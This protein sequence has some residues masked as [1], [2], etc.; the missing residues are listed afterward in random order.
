MDNY[1]NIATETMIDKDKEPYKII[2]ESDNYKLQANGEDL[3]FVTVKVADN[4]GNICTTA[5]N[6]LYFSVKGK[7]KFLTAYNGENCALE[8][9]YLPTMKLYN[10]ELVVLVKSTLEAG[11]IKLVVYGDGIQ[12]EEVYLMSEKG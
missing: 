8:M 11:A 5:A 7:G 9:L 2:L 1:K 4:I 3:V 6:Q 10:G 12:P